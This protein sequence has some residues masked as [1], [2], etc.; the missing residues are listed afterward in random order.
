MFFL[1]FILMLIDGQLSYLLSSIFS[2]HLMI[3]SH[4]FLL[5]LLYFYHEKDNIFIL[6]SSMVLGI[7]FDVYYL[8]IIGIMLVLLPIIVFIISRVSKSFFFGIFQTLVFYIII[9][10]LFEIIGFVLSYLIGM[11]TM[12]LP[13]FI[14]YSFA[15]TLIYNFLMYLIVHR[16][17][18]KIFF[19]G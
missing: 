3:S 7:I 11:T 8:N 2:Y 9:L 1:L 15:P 14:T 4:L 16:I 13:Q 5:G 12:S 18:K 17:L 6:L 19:E 10:F